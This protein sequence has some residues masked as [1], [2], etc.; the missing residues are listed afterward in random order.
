VRRAALLCLACFHA[1]HGQP[2]HNELLSNDCKSRT[3][4]G[5]E[6]LMWAASGTHRNLCTTHR[7]PAECHDSLVRLFSATLRSSYSRRASRVP[8]S[9]VEK[10]GRCSLAPILDR[11]HLII[12]A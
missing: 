4:L 10:Q 8:I 9:A 6:L 2:C 5:A 7:S 3:R 12:N 11:G 1:L